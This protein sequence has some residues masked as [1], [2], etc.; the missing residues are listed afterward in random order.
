M[1]M[2]ELS[3]VQTDSKEYFLKED[4]VLTAE[5]AAKML[6]LQRQTINKAIR[7]GRL[8]GTLVGQGGWGCKRKYNNETTY[9]DL[10]EWRAGVR[11]YNKSVEQMTIKLSDRV[12]KDLSADKIYLVLTK[13]S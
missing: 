13:D 11:Q 9:R 12:T 3:L 5:E 8:K 7:S 1:K 4:M 10:E 6:G 2:S